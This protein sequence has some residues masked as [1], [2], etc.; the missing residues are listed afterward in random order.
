ML[1]MTAC[2]IAKG[3]NIDLDDESI[4][5][6]ISTDSREIDNETIFVAII[7][8]RF[9]GHSF[10]KSALEKGAKYV[11]VSQICDDVPREKQLLVNDTKQAMI[12]IAS[13]YRDKFDVNVVAVTGSVVKTT[14][15]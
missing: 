13:V 3:L 12:D 15:K 1:G 11:V 2:E 4:I 5:T 8:E 9:D 6:N 14:T 10:V 7:G